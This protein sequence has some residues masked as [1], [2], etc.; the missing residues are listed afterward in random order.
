MI[1]GWHSENERIT[2]LLRDQGDPASVIRLWTSGDGSAGWNCEDCGDWEKCTGASGN[3]EF[4]RK[5]A[6]AHRC[7]RI[8]EGQEMNPYWNRENMEALA[9]G[10]DQIRAASMPALSGTGT[11]EAAPDG[12]FPCPG[13]GFRFAGRMT[14]ACTCQYCGHRFPEIR[15]GGP[16]GTPLT[17]YGTNAFH[18]TTTVGSG[19]SGGLTRPAASCTCRTPAA[20][21]DW[22]AH[23]GDCPQGIELGQREISAGRITINDVRASAGYGTPASPASPPRACAGCGLDDHMPWPAGPGA[24]CSY[25]GQLLTLAA[26]RR[27]ALP[28]YAPRREPGTRCAGSG[29]MTRWGR[30]AARLIPRLIVVTAVA[31]AV[32]V[33]FGS[34]TAGAILI[35]VLA[36]VGVVR[37]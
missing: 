23:S 5:G 16:A 7:L 21:D 30:F 22:R 17:R 36:V 29:D 24:L 9:R 13:C 25:C 31:I 4:A 18:Y 34:V 11:F 8:P 27:P 1:P 10:H 12:S 14:A 19:G 37:R 6:A 2:A 33:S 28:G 15:A 32:L 20:A 26:P 35:C 3:A